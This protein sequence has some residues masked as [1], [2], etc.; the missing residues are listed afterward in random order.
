MG[1]NLTMLLFMY[2]DCLMHIALAL[3]GAKILWLKTLFFSGR[4][5]RPT[6]APLLT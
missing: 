5:E 1:F 2:D 6:E 4:K 3:M